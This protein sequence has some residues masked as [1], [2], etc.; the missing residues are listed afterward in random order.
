MALNSLSST[1]NFFSPIFMAALGLRCW[2]QAFSSYSKWGCP[3]V[4]VCRLFLVVSLVLEY[5]L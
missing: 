3:L 5:G 4:G 1:Y 2:V